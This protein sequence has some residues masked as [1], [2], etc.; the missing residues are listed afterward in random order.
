MVKKDAK[1]GKT[2]DEESKEAITLEKAWIANLELKEEMVL[3][4][5]TVEDVK[6]VCSKL[7]ELTFTNKGKEDDAQRREQEYMERLRDESVCVCMCV[8][9]CR[10]KNMRIVYQY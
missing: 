2:D 6:E 9:V 8:C 5:T 3:M 7:L 4:K 1:E 10:S